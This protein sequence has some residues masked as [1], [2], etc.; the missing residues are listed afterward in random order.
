MT[1]PPAVVAMIVAPSFLVYGLA[2]GAQPWAVIL[3]SLLVG[4]LT[5]DALE[6]RTPM[7][8]DT[9]ENS[10][11]RSSPGPEVPPRDP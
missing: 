4:Y 6:Q 5:V 8:R 1:T 2:I 9:G 7:P 11:H 10:V 3:M